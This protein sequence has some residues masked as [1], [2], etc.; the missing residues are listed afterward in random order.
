MAIEVRDPILKDRRRERER[1][2]SR[3]L[4]ATTER[5]DASRR[6]IQELE[7]ALTIERRERKRLQAIALAGT[8]AEAKVEALIA[9]VRAAY[10]KK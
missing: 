7:L 9:A 4:A 10:P 6:R 1:R 2:L 5:L 3:Q 8:A